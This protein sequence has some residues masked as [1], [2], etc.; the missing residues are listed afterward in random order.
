MIAFAGAGMG[1]LANLAMAVVLG[2]GLGVAGTGTFFAV[3]AAFT[4]AA[5]ILELGA[6]T[7]AVRFLA[8]QRSQHRVDH[9]ASTLRV[10]IVP[11]LTVGVLAGAIIFWAAEPL[12]TILG[13]AADQAERAD[14]YRFLAPFILCASLLAVLL[15]ALRG[16]GRIASV[17]MIQNIAVP[18]VRLVVVGLLLSAGYGV[19]TVLQWWAVGLPFAVAI[20][21]FVL[22]RAMRSVRAEPASAAASSLPVQSATSTSADPTFWRFS[23]PRAVAA[24][25]EIIMEWLDVLVVA[26]L[27]GPGQAGIYAV[28]TRVVR[29]GLLLDQATR[30]TL[31]PRLSALAGT[32][33]TEELRAVFTGATRVVVGLA[34]PVYVSLIIFAPTLLGWFGPGFAQGADALRVSCLGMLV[35]LCAGPLQ[36]VILMAGRSSWQLVNKT[37]ALVVFAV[38]L[39]VLVPAFGIVGASCAWVLALLTDTGRA[40]RQAS[41]LGLWLL[42]GRTVRLAAVGVL[43]FGGVGL[44]TQVWW[45]G[46][47]ALVLHGVVSMSVYGTLV[48]LWGDALGVPRRRRLPSVRVMSDG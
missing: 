16:L 33:R 24:A 15:G 26:I 5:N 30:M 4:I 40:M 31:G 13:D 1:A 12:A 48:W 9:L 10:A 25:V 17:V 19:V 38:A 44:L 23:A 29:V 39:M 7:G 8:R 41:R 6:D 35:V 22:W 32:G 14:A 47:T 45:G 27:A 28:V 20:A 3:L 11:V 46:V 18:L 43:I 34:V 36:S 21:A 37:V 42:D 2:H